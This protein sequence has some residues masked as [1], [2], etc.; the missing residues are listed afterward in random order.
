MLARVKDQDDTS[1]SPLETTNS[2]K[3]VC[4]LASILF[5]FMFC[6]VLMAAF[7]HSIVGVDLCFRIYVTLFSVRWCHGFKI[8]GV[9]VR[10]IYFPNDCQLN[11]STEAEIQRSMDLFAKY[12]KQ[13]ENR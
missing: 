7:Q 10:D 9:T 8:H 11:A 5:N 3:K 12:S 2:V 4:V 1:A 13:I 6:A